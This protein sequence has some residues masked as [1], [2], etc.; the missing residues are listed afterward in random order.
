MVVDLDASN[1]IS[2]ETM[3]LMESLQSTGATSLM[4]HC[5]AGRWDLQFLTN[6]GREEALAIQSELQDPEEEP[7]FVQWVYM[8]LREYNLLALT[9]IGGGEKVRAAPPRCEQQ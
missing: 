3:R 8:V 7:R 4:P 5:Y 2:P 6:L 1:N 9:T